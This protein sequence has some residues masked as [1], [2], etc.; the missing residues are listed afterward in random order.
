MSKEHVNYQQEA[1]R[2]LADERWRA[3]VDASA[4]GSSEDETVEPLSAE[5]L[6]KLSQASR[7]DG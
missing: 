7:E 4:V 2:R 5:E 3:Y 1:V 6:V